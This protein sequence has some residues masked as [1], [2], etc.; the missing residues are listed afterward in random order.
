MIFES[1]R[2]GFVGKEVGEKFPH[3]HNFKGIKCITITLEGDIVLQ[4]C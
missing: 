4:H 2:L 1:T 3:P